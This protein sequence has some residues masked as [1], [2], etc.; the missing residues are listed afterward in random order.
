MK[1]IIILGLVLSVTAESYSQDYLMNFSGKGA[2]TGIDSILVENITQDKSLVLYGG[3]QLRLKAVVTNINIR[4]DAKK[5]TLWIYPNP[6]KEFCSI[7]FDAVTNGNATIEITDLSGRLIAHKENY[8]TNGRQTFH[9]NGLGSGVFYIVV[10]TN[11]NFYTG[12]IIGESNSNGN[13]QIRYGSNS[14]IVAS[15][16]IKNPKSTYAEVIMQYETG[17]RL[18]LTA[19][20]GIYSTVVTD[21]PTDNKI[22]EFTFINCTDGDNNN[23]PVIGIGTQT[24]MAE[25]LKTTKYNDNTAIPIVSD[26]AAWAGLSTPA[27]CWHN[28]DEA[29]NKNIYG[30]L[31]NWYSVSATTNGDKNVCPTGWHVPSDE[32]WTI[33]TDYVGGE[34]VAGGKLKE[35][36][37][38]H[39][40]SPNTA[41]S[42]SSGYTALPA[43]YRYYADGSFDGVGYGVNKCG[44]WWS[45]TE[46]SATGAWARGMFYDYSSVYRSISQSK[47]GAFSVR[48]LQD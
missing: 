20:S 23:Y 33:L 46:G 47:N 43:G 45:S 17:D 42:N 7:E 41:A 13:I 9:I 31:Y 48:C 24:W 16:S 3:D 10:K 21:I 44:Y 26:N 30:A 18:K 1:S 35:N 6:V 28:N 11:N 8:L 37:T 4:S 39:W 22:I 12:K 38:I 15:E 34:S 14:G 29:T 5:R 32:E 36:G 25:N 19:V 27:Y 2:S 40:D